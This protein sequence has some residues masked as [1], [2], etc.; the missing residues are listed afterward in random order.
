MSFLEDYRTKSREGDADSM[1]MTVVDQQSDEMEAEDDWHGI[2]GK[3]L[4]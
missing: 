4:G 3:R 2:D 1:G